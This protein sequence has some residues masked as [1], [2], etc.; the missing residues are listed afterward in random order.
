MSVTIQ[1]IWKLIQKECP[2]NIVKRDQIFFSVTLG[3]G[4]DLWL[5]L[6]YTAEESGLQL[7]WLRDFW[8]L[9]TSIFWNISWKG[10]A[11]WN[12]TF[13]HKSV[14]WYMGL[15]NFFE[16]IFLIFSTAFHSDFLCH[17]SSVHKCETCRHKCTS[18]QLCSPRENGVRTGFWQTLWRKQW[19]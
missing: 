4:T 11:S 15:Y 5:A 7:P 3:N 2:S 19:K 1:G 17:F 10:L 9:W 14:K 8:F 16:N 12:S 6:I 13:C 18:I